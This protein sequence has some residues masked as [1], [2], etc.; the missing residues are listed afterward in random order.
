MS[1]RA[2]A[3]L[4]FAMAFVLFVA[5]L[6]SFAHL[7]NFGT[8]LGPY[9]NVLDA[10]A[11]HERQIPNIITAVNFDY[12]GMDTMG[13][14]FILF[15]AVAGLTLV[16]RTDRAETTA[17]PLPSLRRQSPNR[18]DAVQAFSLLGIALTVAF[19]CYMAVHPH[20]TPGGGFQGGAITAGF[21]ALLFLGLGYRP[22]ERFTPHER[23]EPL[24]A[25]GAVGYV[26]VGIVTLV[27]GGF[28]LA[29]TLPLG[30]SGRLF[31][32]GTIPLINLFVAI[33]VLA[34]FVLMFGEFADETRV[35]KPPA[36]Q[37]GDVA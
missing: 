3:L 2:R 14:E 37:E 4:T 20:L 30:G 36:G 10:V 29:N 21:A 11:P 5:L 7:P 19:G 12:R 17:E 34:G 26:I 23:T 13:E 6:V 24:E 25:A 31:S 28:F 16:L 32:T 27:T 22:F 9:G 15:A 8:Y 33:E 18:T 35:E 1:P